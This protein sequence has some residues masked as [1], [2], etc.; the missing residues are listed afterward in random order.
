[1]I[2]YPVFNQDLDPLRII[3]VVIEGRLTGTY[4]EAVLSAG[5]NIFLPIKLQ[6]H[7]GKQSTQAMFVLLSLLY[8]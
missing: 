4:K 2:L 7:H 8:L 3:Y 5:H 6:G 1:M